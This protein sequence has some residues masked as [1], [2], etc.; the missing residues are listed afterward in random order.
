MV[1]GACL[2]RNKQ[3]RMVGTIEDRIFRKEV[4]GHTHMLRK[5]MAWAIDAD[6]FDL[7]IA[8]NCYSIHIIDRDTATKYICDVETFKEKGQKLNRSFGEQY[9]LEI[10]HWTVQ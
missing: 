9:Y 6:I 8:P 1:M 10:I 5:P 4:H 2:V 7:V 3:G